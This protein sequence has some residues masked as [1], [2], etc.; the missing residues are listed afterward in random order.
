[1]KFEGYTKNIY[2]KQYNH[3]FDMIIKNARH[4]KRKRK[5]RIPIQYS[6]TSMYMGE[7]KDKVLRIFTYET[8]GNL[9]NGRH[10]RMNDIA[11]KQIK[12]LKNRIRHQTRCTFERVYSLMRFEDEL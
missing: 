6:K 5:M 10:R 12:I 4:H 11:T 7:L 9:T 3:I 1:M 2:D 8:Y